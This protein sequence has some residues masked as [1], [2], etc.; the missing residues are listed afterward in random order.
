MPIVALMT[1]YGT[2]DY[3]VAAL[4]GVILSIA[5]EAQIVDVTHDI[6]PHDVLRGAFVVRQTWPWFKE[7]TVHVAI[8]DPG[9]GSQRRVILGEYA[10][11][12]IVAPDNGLVT[13]VH[14]DFP[15][16]A[17]YSVQNPDFFL[18]VRSATFHGRDLMAPAAAHLAKGADLADFGPA[19]DDPV[20]LPIES[21]GKF[22]GKEVEGRVLYVDRFGTM[23][24][25]IH[26]EQLAQLPR[27]GG[28]PEVW[29]NDTA[30][31]RIRRTF[32]DV[33]PGDVVVLVGGSNLV[34]IAINQGRAVDRFGPPDEA[35]IHIR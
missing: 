35:R 30:I 34:E 17:L 10:G 28:F 8:I 12:Y 7:G 31:G 9:V 20:L 21:E 23:I 11:R 6:E 25:N 18:S 1:D 22:T 32:A 16:A 13:F 19:I 3:Y 33:A 15:R 5:P 29:V 26:R 24:T 14:R 2:K 4:K 27:R